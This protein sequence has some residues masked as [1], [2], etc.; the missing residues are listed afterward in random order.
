VNWARVKKRMTK[1][2][3]TKGSKRI[4]LIAQAR[5][6][7][8]REK[9]L[10][11]KYQENVDKQKQRFDAKVREQRQKYSVN[12]E[13]RTK[14]HAAAMAER[15]TKRKKRRDELWS[16]A[17]AKAKSAEGKLKHRKVLLA[18]KRAALMERLSK[19]QK[20]R[21]LRFTRNLKRERIAS[22]RRERILSKRMKAMKA[23]AGSVSASFHRKKVA[24][25]KLHKAEHLE[26]HEKKAI[27]ELK[28]ARLAAIAQAK[29]LETKASIAG[30]VSGWLM[31]PGPGHT[32]ASSSNSRVNLGPSKPMT[33]QKSGGG[34]VRWTSRLHRRRAAGSRRRHAQLK[35]WL[36]VMLRPPPK[37]HV[38]IT[39]LA[40]WSELQ[41]WPI[42][43]PLPLHC[44]IPPSLLSILN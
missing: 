32:G 14:K 24:K 26:R 38:A 33:R 28:R 13:K 35:A 7:E 12:N 30:G 15:K 44:L 22:Q 43:L 29:K 37:S 19:Q 36:K 40:P 5:A 17:S 10:Q 8:K 27:K 20:A 23:I 9:H 1:E 4:R 39:R 6:V 11:R 3:K 31:K 41:P 18:K 42:P 21:A 2:R 16:K 25:L 34:S